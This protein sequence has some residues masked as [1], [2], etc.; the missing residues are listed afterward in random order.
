MGLRPIWH[1]KSAQIPGSVAR[2]VKN[3]LAGWVRITSTL[4]SAE[5]GP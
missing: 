5:G 4:Q 3:K 2:P 1:S